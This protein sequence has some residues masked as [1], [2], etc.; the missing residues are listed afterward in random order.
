M[1]EELAQL[2]KTREEIAA[3]QA[4]VAM[5][6]ER[7]KNLQALADMAH[8]RLEEVSEEQQQEFMELL[9]IRIKVTGPPPPM[10]K[11]LVCSVAEWF[12]TRE[13]LVPNLA[14]GCWDRIVEVVRFPGGGLTARQKGGLAPR[15]RAGGVPREGA[16]RCP[17]V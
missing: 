5:G 17:L 15:Y 4:E 16:Y 7:A 6:E 12:R 10:R 1:L 3:W 2:E 11:G 14:D 8:H 13:R 9:D